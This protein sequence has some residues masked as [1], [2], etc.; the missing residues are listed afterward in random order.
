MKRQLGFLTLWL[1]FS[2]AVNASES[3]TLERALDY[4]LA[5]NPDARIAQQRIAAAQAGLEQ[6]NS[7]FWPRLQVQSSY[8]RTDNPMMVFGSILNQRAY[9]GPSLNFNDVPD[10]DDLNARGIVTVPLYAGGRNVAGRQAAKANTEASKQ[11]SAAVRNALGFEVSQTFYTVL[12]TRQ[13]IHA[14][15]AAVNSFE[16]N[17]VVA[18]KRLDGGTLLKS[19][20]LDI[21]VRLAQSREDL[22]RARNANI[23]AERALR[24]LLGIEG[25]EFAVAETAPV[26]SAPDAE[27]FSQRPEL[28]AAR[29]RES[30]AQAQV[31]SSKSGYQPRVSAFGSLDHDYGWVT[32]GDGN[33]YTAGVMLQWDLW[34]GFSTRAKAREAKA[35]LESAR[36]EQRKLRLALDLEVEQARLELK[37]ANERLA[38]SSKAVEQAEESASLTRNRFEQGLAISTQ[39]ID[40]ETALVAARVRRA[41]AESDQHIAIAALRKALALPQ[42]DSQP[43]RK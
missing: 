13:F 10:V 3:W 9:P 5:H 27:D 8:A 34:D 35:N 36:E 37:A 20:A 21:E 24:N 25:G 11:D 39:L 31:R 2:L 19:D 12:K 22:V 30:A 4:A 33:S 18:Q 42:L 15:E 40:S 29:E 38:V 32:G 1:A 23:L 17:L 6:A 26:I 14:A 7:A 43:I 41:E 16:T 28:A